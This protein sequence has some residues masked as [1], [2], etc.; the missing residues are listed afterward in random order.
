[1]KKLYFL[2]IT[3]GITFSVHSQQWT[4]INTGYDYIFKAIDFPEG[5]NNI[6]FAGGQS[7]TYQGDGIVIKT[8]DGGNTWSQLWMGVQQG[9]EGMSFPTLQTGYVCGW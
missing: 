6:G 1:M 3:I 9:I 5:Q 8:T 7:V 4:K 2:I